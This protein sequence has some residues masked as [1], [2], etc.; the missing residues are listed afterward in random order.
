MLFRSDNI[1]GAPNL[2]IE[3]VSPSTE[4]KDRREKKNLYEKFGVKEYIIVFSE[5]EYLE[6]YVLENGK[7]GAPEIMNWDEV[8][9]L[10]AFDIEI[11]LWEIFEKELPKKEK[12]DNEK[13]NG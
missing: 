10:K 11:N 8:L 13:A 5:R 7:Y 12:E 4:L 3:I 6:R 9:K 1:Q 2:I